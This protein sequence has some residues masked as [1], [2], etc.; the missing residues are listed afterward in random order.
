MNQSRNIYPETNMTAPTTTQ[1]VELD[2]DDMI[3][4]PDKYGF[5]WGFGPVAK[6]DPTDRKTKFT[7]CERA[8]YIVHKD[9][10]LMMQ[11]FGPTYF[12]DMANGTSGKVRD[13][14]AVRDP[15]ARDL[16]LRTNIRQLQRMVLVRALDQRAPRGSHMIVVEKTVEVPVFYGIGLDGKPKVFQSQADVL[17]S[18]IDFQQQ[19]Q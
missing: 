14:D 17:A 3:D 9:V 2:L 6:K 4:H 7:V 16:K 11:Y 15:C 13:Q 18:I 12:L 1:P 19:N 5:D 8:P 10:A